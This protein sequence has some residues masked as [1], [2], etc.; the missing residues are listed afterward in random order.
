M[1]AAE[2][3]AHIVSLGL[4]RSGGFWGVWFFTGWMTILDLAAKDGGFLVIGTF[5]QVLALIS[6]WRFGVKMDLKITD[7]EFIITNPIRS[8]RIPRGNVIEA[9]ATDRLLLRVKDKDW[10]ITIGAVES[11]ATAWYTRQARPNPVPMAADINAFLRGELDLELI[12]QRW[13]HPK[14]EAA[15]VERAVMISIVVTAIGDLYWLIHHFLA[16]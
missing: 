8:W 12:D 5:C 11:S 9:A 4:S 1:L 16:T 14:W 15:K 7:S 3:S 10:R 6:A 2:R 13:G